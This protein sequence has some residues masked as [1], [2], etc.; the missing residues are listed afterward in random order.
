MS[1]NDEFKNTE[2]NSEK[3]EEKVAK[4]EHKN[5]ERKQL[6]KKTK[7]YLSVFGALLAIIVALGAVVIH[8]A[9]TYVV[10]CFTDYSMSPTINSEIYNKEGNLYTQSGFR[11]KE[12]N[13][14][15]YGLIEPMK[16]C[17]KFKR[18]DIVAF[19]E[20][21][22]TYFFDASRIVGLP[23][24]KVKLDY[25]GNLYIN[26]EVVNQPID[27]KYL[28]INWGNVNKDP[29]DLYYET[30][31]GD[32]EYYLLKDNRYYYQNDSRTRGAYKLDSFY[33]KVI[34]I[35]GTCEIKGSSFI[36]CSIPWT[37]FI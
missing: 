8:S 20:S 23:G 21:E 10:G 24:E 29:K 5:K 12:G 30:T 17:G 19:R 15:E 37:R 2:A 32:G 7:I 35:Q 28:E 34:A 31:L 18:F 14:V 9:L 33:G 27:K 16:T 3:T 1:I 36:N 11:E 13:I 6:D 4:K 26:D 22:Q 25:D